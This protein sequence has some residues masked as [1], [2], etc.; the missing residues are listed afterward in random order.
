MKTRYLSKL[1]RSH[2]KEALFSE[3]DKMQAESSRLSEMERFDEADALLDASTE[4]LI[5]LEGFFEEV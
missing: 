4:I 5:A 1:A 2:I 3:V